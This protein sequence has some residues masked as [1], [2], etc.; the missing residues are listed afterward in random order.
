M[1]PEIYGKFQIIHW[2]REQKVEYDDEF[3]KLPVQ[4]QSNIFALNGTIESLINKLQ[5]EINEI[6]KEHGN[7]YRDE[8]GD[9]VWINSE[10]LGE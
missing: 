8:N 9:M 5:S 6:A 1:I 3:E 2:L 7:S 10:L 4:H